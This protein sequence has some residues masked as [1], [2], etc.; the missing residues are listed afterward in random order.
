MYCDP[1]TVIH[2]LLLMCCNS[3]TVVH[4]L[5]SVSCVTGTVVR[6]LWPV[7][8]GPCI[9]YCVLGTVVHV[10]WSRY[11]EI[12]QMALQVG[13]LLLYLKNSPMGSLRLKK[14]SLK[15]F[16]LVRGQH[17]KLAELAELEL[18]DLPCQDNSECG[19]AETTAG[20]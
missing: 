18:G 4:V 10:L 1:C 20:E 13:Q 8:C 5:W 17:L 19:Q 14:L 3:C 12:F 9:V 16:L 11:C 6:V 7:Y 2:V 15:D